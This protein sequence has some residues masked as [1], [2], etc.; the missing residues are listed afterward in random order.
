MIHGPVAGGTGA[1]SREQMMKTVPLTQDG[2]DIFV[3]DDALRARVFVRIR[4]NPK[5]GLKTIRYPTIR[6]QQATRATEHSVQLR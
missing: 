3:R 5:W 4:S 2:R 6:A 1:G